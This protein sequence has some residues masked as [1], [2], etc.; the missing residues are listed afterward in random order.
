[1]SEDTSDHAVAKAAG[2]L[3]AAGERAL[4]G[5]EDVQRKGRDVIAATREKGEA[6]IDDTREKSY[7]AAAETNRLFQEHPIAALAAAAAAGAIVS[8]FIPRLAVGA[9]AGKAI[10]AVVG[11]DVTQKLLSSVREA[12]RRTPDRDAESAPDETAGA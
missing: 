7:R 12:G 9:K 8:I 3:R 4:S 5:I 6:L 11:S 2:A 10:K 1:M